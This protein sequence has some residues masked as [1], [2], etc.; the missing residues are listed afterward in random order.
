MNKSIKII[1][2]T[3]FSLFLTISLILI[4][5]SL[6]FFKFS[7][8]IHQNPIDLIKTAYSAWKSNDYQNSKNFNFILLGLDKRDDQLEKT[9]TTDTIIFASFNFSNQKINLF[10]LP[11]DIWDYENNAKINHIYP[12]SKETSDPFSFIQN[13]YSKI[14]GQTINKT[15]IITTDSLINFVNIIGGVDVYLENGFTDHEYPNPEYIKNPSP[16]IPIYITVSYPSG[17]IHLDE[18][19]VAPFVRS[20]KSTENHRAAGTDIG[21]IERQQL[22]IDAIISKIRN[23]EFFTRYTNIVN[24]YNFWHQEIITNI[25]DKDLISLGINLKDSYK[26]ISLIKITIP[27]GTNPKKS[28]IYHPNAFINRQWVFTTPSKNYSELHQFINTSL[29]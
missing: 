20:R 22:L 24:L 10:S 1:I 5:I 7:Q 25:T 3:F 12:L 23:P 18:S 16:K 26:N 17:W 11:R 15:I 2:F 4:G 21:R 27:V 9:E 8:K 29:N 28:V 13:N 19:N 14:T 6:E